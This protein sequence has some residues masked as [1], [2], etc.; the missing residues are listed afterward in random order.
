MCIHY[1]NIIIITCSLSCINPVF[2][3]NN[4]VFI[5]LI[6]STRINFLSCV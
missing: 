2:Y 3:L 5:N 1:Y 4:S 6:T